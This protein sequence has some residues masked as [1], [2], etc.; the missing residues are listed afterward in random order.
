LRW[1]KARA[2]SYGYNHNDI[3][4]LPQ[5]LQDFAWSAPLRDLATKIGISDVGLKKLF[6]SYGVITPP[7]GY[8]NKV[9]AGKS[10]P[11]SPRVAPR[12]PGEH[13][14]TQLDARFAN[15]LTVV[16]PMSSHGPFASPAVPEDLELLYDAELKVIGSVPAPRKLERVHSGL[17][18]I[19]KKEDQRRERVAASSWHWDTPKFESALDKRPLRILNALFL[20]LGRRG[21]RAAAHERDDELHATAIIGDTRV[22]VQ[23]RI[24]GKHRTV[25]VHGRDRP[26]PD[27]PTSMP[28]A[29]I[30]DADLSGKLRSRWEDDQSGRL[31]T[32]LGPIAASV[33]V[34]GEANFRHG[35][36]QAEEWAEQ[37]RRREEKRRAE[38]IAARNAVRLK[39]LR[40]SGDLLRQAEDL[41]ILI[42]RVREA[43]TAGSVPLEDAA[44]QDWEKWANA[45]A[46]LLDPILSGQ[47]R[48]HLIASEI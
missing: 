37:S 31:E 8:W 38:A 20:A 28:L 44:L 45:E 3:L 15:L 21:Y 40:Q 10:V 14:R 22:G 19:F 16:E 39:H 11:K 5:D 33:I 36:K 18:Q 29:L 2:V 17:A 43:V 26:A 1:S 42:A 13:G 9:N 30:I 23:I 7:Q 24:A 35:L 34:A 47:I 46:D 4:V 6:I 25:R 32:K 27:L 12:R 41:R 48:T